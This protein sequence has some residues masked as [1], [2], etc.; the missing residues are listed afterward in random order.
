[1]EGYFNLQSLAN[2]YDLPLDFCLVVINAM[3]QPIQMFTFGQNIMVSRTYET[4]INHVFFTQNYPANMAALP[5]TNYDD[6]PTIEEEEP[7]DFLLFS[8]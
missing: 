3:P 2:V 1:M 6:V 5:P 7:A 4:Q 8:H